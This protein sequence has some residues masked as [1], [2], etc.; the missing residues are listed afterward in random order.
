MDVDY[1]LSDDISVNQVL[2][3]DLAISP[4]CDGHPVK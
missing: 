4:A 3:I 2:H 1:L